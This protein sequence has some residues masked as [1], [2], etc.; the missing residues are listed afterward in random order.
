MVH[1]ALLMMVK[2]E[3]KRLAVSL[4]SIKNT[5]DSMIIFD[6]GS[7]D[8]TIDILESFSEKN[9]IPLFL[10]QGEF[11]DFSTSRNV[12]FDFADTFSDP[13]F[14]LLLDCNDELKGGPQL[15][16]FAKKHRDSTQSAWLMCQEWYSGDYIKYYNLRFLRAR[17]GWRYRGVVH[18]WLQNT[19]NPD[20]MIREKTPDGIILYQD[21]T[22][23]DDKTGKRFYRDKELLLSEYAKQ[24]DPRTVFYLAQTF[25]CLKD[26][27]NAYKYYKERSEMIGFYE[28]VFQ[29]LLHFGKIA[30]RYAPL[31][32]LPEN[33]PQEDDSDDIL[34]LKSLTWDTA[35]MWFM[36]AFQHTPRAEPLYYIAD[37]YRTKNAFLQSFSL[38]KI[39]LELEFP[40]DAV[41]TVEKEIYDYKRHHLMGIVAFYCGQFEIG[42]IACRKAIQAGKQQIDRDNLVHYEKNLTPSQK[43]SLRNYI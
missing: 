18:E 42:Y 40:R 37:Y 26:D 17:Q 25:S 23:D 2:N 34:F 36:K 24:K 5:V 27:A 1:I 12:L 33:K 38:C 35:I 8:S 29:S 19:N 32:E 13:D 30:Q 22:L 11:V 6:T 14:L 43:K 41:L 20:I 10:K 31:N 16:K 3:E 7:T 4:D 39:A 21:R 28:E 15:R 9:N